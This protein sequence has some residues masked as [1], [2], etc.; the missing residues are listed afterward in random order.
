MRTNGRSRDRH[1]RLE[2]V[3]RRR[4]ADRVH[5]RC[6]DD[7]RLGGKLGAERRELA[8]NRLEIL[9]RIAARRAGDVHE[10]HQHLRAIEMLQEP[11]AEPFALVRAF[12]EPGHV[13][14]D[15][16]AVAAQRHDAEVRARAW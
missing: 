4:I 12:D 8:L 16:A 2:R 1:V 13:G 10:V 6:G 14:D 9:D 7:L 11:I 5:L 3:D 15:E